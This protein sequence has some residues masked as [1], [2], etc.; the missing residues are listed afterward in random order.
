V[1]TL[2][3]PIPQIKTPSKFISP[4]IVPVTYYLTPALEFLPLHSPILLLIALGIII[5]DVN[6]VLL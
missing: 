3:L 2:P 4:F 1:S 5:F 6:S